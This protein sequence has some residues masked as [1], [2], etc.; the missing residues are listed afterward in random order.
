MIKS[1]IFTEVVFSVSFFIFTWVLTSAIGFKGV[2]VAHALNYAI[3]W[4]VMIVFIKANLK[5]SSLFVKV[6]SIS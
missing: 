3:Y 6:K 4:L 5:N 2:A 1:F